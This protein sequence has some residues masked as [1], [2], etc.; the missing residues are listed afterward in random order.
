M[1]EAVGE[2]LFRGVMDWKSKIQ[3]A[4]MRLVVVAFQEMSLERGRAGQ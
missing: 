1:G 3:A 4:T 2:S